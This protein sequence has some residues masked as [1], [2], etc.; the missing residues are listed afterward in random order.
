MMA[1]N[2]TIPELDAYL[3][4]RDD[5]RVWCEYCQLWH[6]HGAGDGHKVAHCLVD[7]SAYHTTGYVLTCRGK[8][9]QEMKQRK[10]RRLV[11]C[12]VCRVYLSPAVEP[13]VCPRCGWEK[14]ERREQS[15][16]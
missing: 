13:V 2:V 5:Y 1:D 15:M 8:W 11:R 9:T 3:D 10:R 6:I 7:N 16:R 14:P 4:E 12:R